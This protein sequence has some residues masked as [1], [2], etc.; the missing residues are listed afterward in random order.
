MLDRSDEG[1]EGLIPIL[2]MCSKSDFTCII[3]FAR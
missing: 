2:E 3:A 1:F